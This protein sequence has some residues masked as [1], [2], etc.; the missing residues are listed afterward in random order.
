MR[1]E[2]TRRLGLT[3]LAAVTAVLLAAASAAAI[4]P[5]CDPTDPDC[6]GG[7]GGPVVSQVNPDLFVA[8]TNG[9]TV[10]DSPLANINCGADC[11]QGGTTYNY[12]RTCEEGDC[13][14]NNV[15]TVRSIRRC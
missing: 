3:L 10:Q 15:D 6:G 12:Q 4:P 14:Y 11:E 7:G 13:F 1:T 9:G 2:L 5:E 8:S